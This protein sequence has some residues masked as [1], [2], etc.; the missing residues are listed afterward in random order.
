M[1]LGPPARPAPTPRPA[2]RSALPIQPTPPAATAGPQR[3]NVEITGT[4][5][6]LGVLAGTAVA[7]AVVASVATFL[8]GRGHS[9]AAPAPRPAV[10]S[11]AAPAPTPIPA[12]RAAAPSVALAADDLEV[13]GATRSTVTLAWHDGNGGR[14]PYVVLTDAGAATVAPQRAGTATSHVVTGLSPA[15][16]YCFTV[17]TGTGAVT[18]VTMPTCV[19]TRP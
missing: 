9:A 1:A 6:V 12:A 18:P 14:V 8:A 3:W 10:S 16:D 15:T 11:A 13:T 4:G 2:R 7:I 17:A 19:R 5:G